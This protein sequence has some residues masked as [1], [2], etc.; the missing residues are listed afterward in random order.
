MSNLDQCPSTVHGEK[1]QPSKAEL[2]GISRVAGT[3]N[4]RQ[5]WRSAEDLAD[6]SDFRDWM[7]KEFPAGASELSRAEGED[8]ET[9]GGETRRTFLKIMG[10]SLALAGAATVPGCRRPD[11]KILAYSKEV[12]EEIIPGKP[13]FYATSMPRP[14]GGAEG[15]LVETHEGRPTKIEGNPLHPTNRGKCS[16]WA[17]ASI[18][19]L[20]DPDRLNSPIFKNPAR[21]K[22][23]ATWD[24]FRA[25]ASD[26]FAPYQNGG[27]GLAFVVGKVASPTRRA[28][29]AKLKAKY[30][31]AIWV[32]YS[33]ADSRGSIDGTRAAFDAP[34]R[35]VLNISKANTKVIVSLDRDFLYHE[36]AELENSRNFAK[37]REVIT[38]SD[39]MTRLYMVESAFSIT[40]GQADHRLAMAPSRISAFAVELAKFLLPKLGDAKGAALSNAVAAVAVPAGDDM[41]PSAKRYLEECA[42]DLLD[43]PNRGKTLLLAGPTQPPAVHALVAAIN[44]A[45]GNIGNSI[46]Y[47]P[48]TDDEAADSRGNIASLT[49]KLAS[50]EVS[51]LVCIGANPAYDAP[52]FAAAMDKAQSITLSVEATETA[53]NSTWALNGASYL[54]SWGDTIASDGTISP[55][56]PMI[57]PLYEPAMSDIEFMFLLA[58]ADM[59]AKVDGYQIVRDAWKGVLKSDGPAFEQTWRRA[60]H[61]GLVPGT[62]KPALKPDVDYA[63]VAAAVGGLKLAPAPSTT[64]LDLSITIGHPHDGRYANISWL[65]ELP[66]V[67]T[68]T[69]WDNP[70]LMSPR[71]AEALDVLPAGFTRND[72]MGRIYTTPKYPTARMIEVKVGG[73]TVKAAAWI[74]PGM[75]DHTLL[76]TLGYGRENAGRVGDGVGFNFYPLLPTDTRAAT[77]ATITRLSDTMMIAST[78]NHWSMAGRTS[79]VRAVDLPAWKKHGDALQEVVDTFYHNEDKVSK[80][81]FGERLGELKH[82]PPG[83]SIYANPFNRGK[84]NPDPKDIKPGNPNGPAYQR[85]TPPQYTVGPQWAMTIDQNACTGCGACT[86]ACQAENNIPVVGKKEV[87]KGRE[88]TW[89]RVDR[90][91]TGDMDGPDQML[92]QPVA[93]VHCENAPCETV[94]PV[95]ATIH[96]PE[97]I[98]YMTY[99]RCIGTR[100]C[101][102]NCPYKVRRF[103]FFDYGVTKFNGDY[104]GKDFLD[105]AGEVQPGAEGIT[106]SGAFNKIN[107][108]LIPP[109][110]R[111][112]LDEISRMQKNPDVTVR[113]RG[114]MEKCSYCIQRINSAKIETKLQAL[115]GIPEG[116]FQSACQQACPSDAIIFGDML[117]DGSRVKASKA[118]ARSYQLLGYLDTRPRTSHM[119][120]V[121]N[122]NP[123]LCD[124]A[125]KESWEN[126]FEHEAGEHEGEGHEGGDHGTEHPGEPGKHS[127]IDP[128]HFV[129]PRSKAADRGY[130]LSLKVLGG[131]HA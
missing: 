119:V 98:N 117:L 73:K 84:A 128:R 24:D 6:T 74:M 63:K 56:Q 80:L 21:G 58:G 32:D 62:A 123:A 100:Y 7:E 47:V 76:C 53:A 90:Y 31:K 108:N 89:I 114:V 109:R 101:A 105:N 130:A 83:I 111:D 34:M 16:T 127:F 131:S 72:D 97:G 44:H 11:H 96:G 19:A 77:G 99:N 5:V 71:T 66:E 107:P 52:G 110:L 3:V 41:G 61:D 27:Q 48:L 26:H 115:D 70:V 12:P 8:A 112:K 25:W 94:C 35:E 29:A 102:N 51:T 38:T 59:S 87:A 78:Q 125:R 15:L 37:S 45:L 13:L 129:D 10:A 17:L 42:K 126:P 104:L 33:P 120:R 9:A 93:C 116:F 36:P 57:A 20:Y 39:D 54:E 2:A 49:S 55:V 75:P 121:M 91:F 106:G 30:P 65:Q 28:L 122:P 85:N 86:I 23:L 82:N 124:A 4:G 43:A 67:G 18:M 103:N 68:R 79:I 64:A 22:L 1:Q 95:N 118:H 92:H 50:G 88:M 69:V 40:G 81:K 60:L 46:S 14:D 113:S